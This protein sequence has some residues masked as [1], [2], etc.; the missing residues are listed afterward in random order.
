MIKKIYTN[1]TGSG[2]FKKEVI[3]HPAAREVI[4][5]FPEE[6]RG[7]VGLLLQQLQK[8]EILL[9]PHSRLMSEVSP[10]VFELRPRSRDGI[11]RVFYL[12]KTERGI[13]VFHAFQKKTEKTPNS[14]LK[15]AK[16]RLNELLE[17]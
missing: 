9:M 15:L 11:F 16:K 7:K 14:E 4:R 1:S 10:G 5:G 13:L 2:T 12:L 6:V 17:K 8:G 3:F